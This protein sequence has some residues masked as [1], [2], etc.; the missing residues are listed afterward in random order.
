MRTILVARTSS[1]PGKPKRAVPLAL[2]VALAVA[3][4]TLAVVAGP[5]WAETITVNPTTDE[6]NTDGDCSLREA[7]IAANTDAPRDAC[8]AGTERDTITLP[9]GTYTLT[10]AGSDEDA[11]ATGDLDITGHTFINGAG[12]RST[13]VVGGAGFD[14][15]IFDIP[16]GG[17]TVEISGLTITNGTASD[18]QGGGV[19]N[20]T[21]RLKLHQVAVS[22][23]TSTNGGGI[24]SSGDGTLTI[25]DSTVSGNSADVNGAIGQQLGTATIWNS[26]ISGNQAT[27]RFGGVA[28]LGATVNIQ[29]ST[30]A[31]NTSP[32]TGGGIGTS[33]AGGVVPTVSLKNTIVSDN[34]T[35]N[36][37]TPFGGTIVLQ[38]NNISSDG[39]SS[40]AQPSDQQNTDPLLSP[41]ANIGGPT[42]T[43]A[44]RSGSPAIDAGDSDQTTD[45]RG[46]TRP[47][48]GDKN[49][50]AVD[51]IGAFELRTAPTPPK[52]NIDDVVIVEGKKGAS[53]V[54]FKVVLSEPSDQTVTVE[55]AT[56]DGS[57]TSTDTSKKKGDY[58]PENGIL[59][60]AP[61]ETNGEITVSVKGDRKRE[62]DETFF[63]V[64]S[65]PS[66]ATIED[67]EGTGTISDD[68]KKK[69][70]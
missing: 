34:T 2:A 18:D 58:A 38:G 23:N 17:K 49:G 12:A 31:S 30:I 57:A 40:L 41:L 16:G 37:A 70:R 11:A 19:R 52:F 39:C 43:H 63:V 67:G 8:T 5:A 54:T 21:G 14:D 27:F 44:L 65:N 68:D 69:R 48:D 33:N 55:Y 35:N 24:F 1:A 36:C 45:Q 9:A 13:I 26:T 32:N 42:D 4:L 56:K 25:I 61:G 59:T 62:G 60:F 64:L 6:D 47:Q 28:A 53:K 66:N 50:S 15:R 10:I 3:T 22:G 46:V 29:S 20:N 7:V 51:D